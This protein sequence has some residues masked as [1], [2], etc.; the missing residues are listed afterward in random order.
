[1]LGAGRPRNGCLIP[2][3]DNRLFP[4]VNFLISS[5]AQPAFYLLDTGGSFHGKKAMVPK[6]TPS[7][8]EIRK[9]GALCVIVTV[10]Y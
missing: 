7:I 6:L 8:A 4:P 9:F 1:M 2:G 10:F 3:S 5:E